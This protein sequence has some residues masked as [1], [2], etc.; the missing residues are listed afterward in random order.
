MA[1]P[2]KQAVR[3]KGRVRGTLRKTAGGRVLSVTALG[4]T[5]EKAR[6]RAYEAV[7]QIHFENCHYRRDIALNPVV[8]NMSEL[9]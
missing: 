7:S 3:R 1:D 9:L 4:S 6:T 5:L 8:A 2:K